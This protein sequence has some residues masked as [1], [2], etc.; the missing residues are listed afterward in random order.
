[1]E[2]LLDA[3]NASGEAG[4]TVD[5]VQEGG[6]TALHYVCERDSDGVVDCVRLLLE[7]GADVAQVDGD[8]WTALHCAVRDTRGAVCDPS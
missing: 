6:M 7:R 1:M 2:V 5:A 8:G 4:A 3:M